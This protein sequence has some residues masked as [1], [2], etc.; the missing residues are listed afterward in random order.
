[1]Q[2]LVKNKNIHFIKKNKSIIGGMKI[3]S[4]MR[5]YHTFIKMVTRLTILSAYRKDRELERPYTNS[6][7]DKMPRE[8]W[9]H[10]KR[11]DYKP[12]CH[13]QQLG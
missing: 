6:K 1:M 12:Q 7:I 13:L 4:T 9:S 2:N 10:S 3:K 8:L 11:M 5:Y